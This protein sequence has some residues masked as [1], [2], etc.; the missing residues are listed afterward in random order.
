MDLCN[1]GNNI[2]PYL[3]LGMV[4]SS[5]SRAVARGERLALASQLNLVE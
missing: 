1:A 3:F 5:I 2:P 4:Q